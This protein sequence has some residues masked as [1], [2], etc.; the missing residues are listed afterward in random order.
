MVRG[1]LK[2]SFATDL[3]FTGH[4]IIWQHSIEGS[5]TKWTAVLLVSFNIHLIYIDIIWQHAIYSATIGLSIATC[6]MLVAPGVPAVYHATLAIPNLALE[7]SMACRVFRAVKLG[8]I[9]DIQVVSLSGTNFRFNPVS[10]GPENGT[11]MERHGFDGSRELQF[12]TNTTKTTGAAENVRSHHEYEKPV[13]LVKENIKTS[14][15]V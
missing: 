5:F 8:H 12:S 3:H 4:N 11:T 2:V 9:K 1:C 7:N 13:S 15:R 6:A 14:D 10:F